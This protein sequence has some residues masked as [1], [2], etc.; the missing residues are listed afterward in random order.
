[1]KLIID[2]KAATLVDR[3]HIMRHLRDVTHNAME[4]PWSAVRK[5]SQTVF[6]AVENGDFCW[7]DR[8]E[9]Q[10]ERIRIA[11][12][13]P[14]QATAKPGSQAGRRAEYLCREFNAKGGCRHRGDHMDGNVNVL[15]LC[16][17]CDAVSRQCAHSVYACDRKLPF[18]SGRMQRPH[19]Q[20]TLAGMGMQRQQYDAPQ[21]PMYIG[22]PKNVQ[23]APRLY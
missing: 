11:M 17:F 6:D 18:P 1:M 8:Q 3:P 5:W 10:N 21:P 15:H 13:G 23:Q 20:F 4:R 12:T 19:Q 22:Q 16:A 14:Q 7:A 2:P 9:I